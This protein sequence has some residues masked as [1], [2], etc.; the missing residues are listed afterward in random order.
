MTSKNIV[1]GELMKA[2]D[3]LRIEGYKT[4]DLD[5]IVDTGSKVLKNKLIIHPVVETSKIATSKEI[6]QTIIM[7]PGI[8]I[9][10][11]QIFDELSN[12]L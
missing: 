2:L 8:S 9:D 12:S 4:I 1:I 10:G 3:D 6:S 5:M 7:D 11:N